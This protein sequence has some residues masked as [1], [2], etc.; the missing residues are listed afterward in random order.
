MDALVVVRLLSL[1]G[2][3]A[4]SQFFSTELSFMI[5]VWVVS[6]S[7]Y[8]VGAIHSRQFIGQWLSSPRTSIPLGLSLVVWSLFFV[9]QFDGS[10]FISFLIHHI[11]G[12]SVPYSDRSPRPEARALKPLR[13]VRFFW[14]LSGFLICFRASEPFRQIPYELL[15]I[16]S[17]LVFLALTPMIVRHGLKFDNTA[18]R[19]KYFT[20]EG[21]FFLAVLLST[22]I[23]FSPYWL[24]LFHVFLWTLIPLH[25]SERSKLSHA[26]Y[27]LAPM[28]VIS[29][30]I[31][32]F[33]Q[34]AGFP[35]SLQNDGLRWHF[36][37]WGH[38]HHGFT[39]FLFFM[40]RIPVL[41]PW[42]EPIS[43]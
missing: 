38:L 33:S 39:Y 14:Y 40:N 18:M 11:S 12:E 21:L 28:V 6:I 23:K 35:W 43:R 31:W 9:F 17:A 8:F 32:S 42:L 5:F 22:T 16:P 36:Q 15:V 7:H 26:G 3:I 19:S 24:V 4:A 20:F 37:F 27:V 1:A 25:T 10:A 41:R 29:F 13:L 2:V 30:V 34:S